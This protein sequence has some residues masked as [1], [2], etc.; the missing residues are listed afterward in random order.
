[1]SS[2]PSSQRSPYILKAYPRPQGSGVNALPGNSQL[3][4]NG[5]STSP[6]LTTQAKSEPVPSHAPIPADKPLEHVHTQHGVEDTHNHAKA[7][8]GFWPNGVMAGLSYVLGRSLAGVLTSRSVASSALLSPDPR[9]FLRAGLG[10]FAVNRFNKAMGWEPPSWLV[11]L[12]TVGVV[13]TLML[14]FQRQQ[15]P[16]LILT[17]PLVLGSV[18]LNR[19]GNEQLE[20]V[21]D[22]TQLS[23]GQKEAVS[24]GSK[25]LTMAAT[26]GVALAIYPK[27]FFQMAKHEGG[28]IK[29]LLDKGSRAALKDNA[30]KM[31]TQLEKTPESLRLMAAKVKN[32]LPHEFQGLNSIA[33]WSHH[34]KGAVKTVRYHLHGLENALKGEV[35]EHFLSHFDALDAKAISTDKLKAWTQHSHIPDAE[36]QTVLGWL[37]QINAKSLGQGTYGEDYQILNRFVDLLEANREQIKGLHPNTQHLLSSAY[38]DAKHQLGHQPRKI[39]F[40]T[41]FASQGAAMTCANGCC[42]GSAFCWADLADMVSSAFHGLFHREPEQQAS[43]PVQVSPTLEEPIQSTP[44]ISPVANLQPVSLATQSRQFAHA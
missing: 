16:H 25:L 10:V 44:L 39:P 43:E 7:Q 24:F 34:H 31:L 33:D 17:A 28:P 5:V 9:Q 23:A 14:G 22:K 2:L 1:M 32:S 35:D 3:T 19:A 15:L 26:L 13:H 36:K 37:E 6:F 41:L 8:R 29:V 27:V 42:F 20:K 11:G 18:L 12:E 4:G 30:Y 38:H 40:I 21:L